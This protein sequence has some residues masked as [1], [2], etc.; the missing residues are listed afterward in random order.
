VAELQVESA[1][2]TKKTEKIKIERKVD[3]LA[4]QRQKLAAKIAERD[5]RV[6]E[7]HRKAD[8]DRRA[9]SD[10]GHE[11]GL[12]YGDPNELLKHARVVSID[13][14]QDN[15]FN[16]NIPRFVDTFDP[17]PL[18]EVKDALK[19]LAAADGAEGEARKQ[20]ATLLEAIGYGS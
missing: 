12:L 13:E 17:E 2:E 7:A 5:E 20:L 15:D 1:R 19:A 11:L 3:K 14:I 9:V 10:V 18:I 6:S 8:D 16:L 4:S